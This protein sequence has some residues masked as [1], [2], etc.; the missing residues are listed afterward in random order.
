MALT[1][2]E[3]I[4]RFLLHLL[5]DGFQRIRRNDP[6]DSGRRAD[7]IARIRQIIAA[8]TPVDVDRAEISVSAERPEQALEP[9][10]PCRY[11]GVA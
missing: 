2:H 9:Q 10:P 7:A 3:F 8:Q 11:C 1:G 5:P 6:L 4:P